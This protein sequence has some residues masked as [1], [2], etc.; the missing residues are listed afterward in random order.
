MLAPD[1]LPFFLL[2][3][4]GRPVSEEIASMRWKGRRGSENVEDRRSM[5]APVVAGGGLIGFIVVVVVMLLGGDPRPVMQQMQQAAPQAGPAQ[6][7]PEEDERAQF[8]SVVLADT[9]DVWNQ[10][11]QEQVG[12]PYVE[13]T[14]IMFRDRVQSACGFQSAATGPFYCPLDTKVYIDLSFFDE[15]KSKLGAP[16]DFAQAY[17]IAHEVGHH[18]QNL[19]G[20][21][22]QVHQLQSRASKEQANELSVRLE[23][24]AD[25]LA[26][27]WANRAQQNWQ[28]LEEGDIEEALT[29]A[30]AIGDDRLQMQSSGV[31]VPESFTHGTSEQRTR[32]FIRGLKTGDIEQGD[33]FEIPYEQL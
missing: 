22:D 5:A 2:G 20:L 6:A 19:L 4:T 26:G 8:V 14:L 32:W 31:V 18:V 1:L 13:P 21:S 3:C 29:A 30:T 28:I 17:V 33:T 16:G 23:L 15:M 12:K 9:E 10:V 25:F 7:P 24:Q 11:F 27:V